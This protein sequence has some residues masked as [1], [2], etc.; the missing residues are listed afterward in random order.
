MRYLRYQGRR[1]IEVHRRVGHATYGSDVEGAY[2]G[3]KVQGVGMIEGMYWR[4]R[5]YG[6]IR[7]RV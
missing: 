7:I 6:G 2:I 5:G 1:C 3:Y 4:R